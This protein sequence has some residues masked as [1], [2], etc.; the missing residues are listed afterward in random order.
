MH[1][2]LH[3]QIDELTRQLGIS[4]TQVDSLAKRVGKL[5]Q[6]NCEIK[7]HNKVCNEGWHEVGCSI[8]ESMKEQSLAYSRTPLFKRIEELVLEHELCNPKPKE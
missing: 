7:I 4:N 5:A 2:D 6:E 8:L 1:E 3:I